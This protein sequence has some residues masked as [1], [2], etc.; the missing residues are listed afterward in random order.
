MSERK[1]RD[2]WVDPEDDPRATGERPVGERDK[3][4]RAP[5]LP[6]GD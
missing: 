3:P 6:L 5:A 4:R 2:M 1:A